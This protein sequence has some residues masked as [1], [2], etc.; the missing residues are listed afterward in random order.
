M[1]LIQ[2]K[3]RFTSGVIFEH[4]QENNSIKITVEL[5]IEENACLENANLRNANLEN[6]N[7]EN[8]NLSKNK[9]NGVTGNMGCF[10][11]L[12][13]ERWPISFDAETLNIGCETYAIE[14]WFEFEDKAIS[15]MDVNALEWW[16]KWKVPLRMI[17][18]TRL[19]KK[20]EEL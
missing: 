12:Q 3:N 6:A 2:I 14:K 15:Q 16:K 10:F 4:K 1:S 9:F 18:E 8:A 11:S 13:I 17:I 19:S 20:I 7:L 5:A